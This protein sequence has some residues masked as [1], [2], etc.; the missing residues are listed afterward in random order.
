MLLLD[1]LLQ[2][3]RKSKSSKLHSLCSFELFCRAG[4]WKLEGARGERTG[5]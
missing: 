4:N 3:A 2:G 5:K 1:S